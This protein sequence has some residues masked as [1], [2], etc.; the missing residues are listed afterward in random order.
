VRAKQAVAIM[1]KGR[2]W[3]PALNGRTHDPV[4]IGQQSNSAHSRCATHTFRLLRAAINPKVS[5]VYNTVVLGVCRN[6]I[7]AGPNAEQNPNSGCNIKFIGGQGL[8]QKPAMNPPLAE[9]PGL[10]ASIADRG[11]PFGPFQAA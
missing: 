1:V 10:W 11:N 5:I 8:Q 9:L 3:T 6:E 4:N 2:D 7:L